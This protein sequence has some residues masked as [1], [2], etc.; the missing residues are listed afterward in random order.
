MALHYVWC[1]CEQAST[2]REATGARGRGRREE[3][4]GEAREGARERGRGRELAGWAFIIVKRIK[5]SP[6]EREKKTVWDSQFSFFSF[7]FLCQELIRPHLDVSGVL[8]GSPWKS[9]FNAFPWQSLWWWLISKADFPG[10]A[11]CPTA[12][13]TASDGP[14]RLNDPSSRRISG[15]LRYSPDM[16]LGS[17]EDLLSCSMREMS[18]FGQ[19]SETW[20]SFLTSGCKWAEP[21]HGSPSGPSLRK[22]VPEGF[23][24]VFFFSYFVIRFS[25][26]Q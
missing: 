12:T 6:G 9:Q 25:H 20:C 8:L 7:L 15:A 11:G 1:V 3:R 4:E 14:S 18:F 21:G 10:R 17:G 26:I 16:E 24:F 23:K 22:N 5:M 2:T 19:R 13:E